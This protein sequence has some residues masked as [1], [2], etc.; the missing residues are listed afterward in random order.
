MNGARL[1]VV[2]RF[3]AVAIW[4]TVPLV[5]PAAESPEIDV[6]AGFAGRWRVGS[7]TPLV[8]SSTSAAF[9]AG[10]RV[11]V[12][13]EDMDGQLVASPA[14]VVTGTGRAEARVCVRFGRPS[15]RYRLSV[16]S[17]TGLAVGPTERQ[18]GGAIP[19][20][21]R[22][23]VCYGDLPAVS[24]A[25]RLVDRDQG[26][27]TTVVEDAP[28]YAVSSARGYDGADAIVLCGSSIASLPAEL[29][30]AVD[31]W[32]RD[33]GRLV[34]VCGESAGDVAGAGTAA[35]A[36]LPGH[37]ER[38]V[39]VRRLGAVEAY[40]RAGGLAERV[41]AAGVRVPQ[42]AG[43]SA[44]VVEVA[45]VEGAAGQPLVVR[46]ARGLGTVTWIGL[47]LDAE[48]V[49]G[50]G[51]SENLLAAALAG[52]ARAGLDARPLEAGGMPDLAGQLHAALD[53][54]PLA[55]GGTDRQVDAGGRPVPFEM[56]AGL[57]LLYVLCLY[58]LDWWLVARS[59]RPWLSWFTLPLLAAGF[60]TAIWGV[61]DRWSGTR[62]PV[63]SAAD[64]VDV[65][66]EGRRVRGTAWIAVHA[67]GND[68]LDVAVAGH[69]GRVEDAAASWWGVAGGGFGGLDAA[70]PHPSLAAADYAYG[71][72][73][74][75][76]ERVPVAAGASRLFEAEWTAVVD[77]PPVES[78]LLRTAQGTLA[79]SVAHRLPFV[80]DNCRLLH[81][82]WLY[83]IGRLA[84]GDRYDT[85]TGRGPRS[86]A[87]ALTRR[88][89]ARD[90]DAPIRWDATS[91]D[92]ARIIEVAGLH[93]AA[94]GVAYTGL[95]AGR[96]ARLDLSPL[97]VVD[98]AVLV[99][100]IA[101]ADHTTRW[102]VRAG[103]A[104]I[105][106]RE[107]APTLCRIVIPLAA[108]AAP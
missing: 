6:V 103:E 13:A 1:P 65:D 27:A 21:T 30:A 42:F 87:S 38:L 71:D 4:A 33:G 37:V 92:V 56:I 82:G 17:S 11:N 43:E 44:G 58:P 100:T 83:D 66:A 3:V 47:D 36:W 62:E 14:V 5:A 23:V 32:V 49:R 94:G 55:D 72:S 67:H 86:L 95:D 90:R 84:P 108:E 15:G 105:T 85:A 75:D 60:T 28:P 76:L 40:A 107:A 2:V 39:P 89:A 50:W 57:G 73:L 22:V 68:H 74:A 48:P 19:S 102:T 88:A 59:D 81:A 64:M 26:T 29:V 18:L 106:A 24:R 31:A 12:W 104:A 9:A 70:V 25:A 54:P 53:S 79:G 10:D 41:P 98:R 46:F 99:G 52:R 96:L 69:V 51:G 34:F 101:D 80:L 35:T 20:T 45:A 93:T 63:A 78:T 77:E 61:K 8:L 91:I 97:L 16:G 7:W